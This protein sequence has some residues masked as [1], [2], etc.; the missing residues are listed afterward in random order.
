MLWSIIAVAIAV[1]FVY[2][3]W[4]C[5]SMALS[6]LTCTGMGRI[7]S[8]GDG[9]SV[10]MSFA[11]TYLAISA[12]LHLIVELLGCGTDGEVK[13]EAAVV[14]VPLLEVVLFFVHGIMW[15]NVVFRDLLNLI[16]RLF[17]GL[18]LAAVVSLSCAG[19]LVCSMVVHVH[20]VHLRCYGQSLQ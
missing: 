11:V 10:T 9:F 16:W 13:T 15:L 19:H 7:V 14:P 17:R 1:D 20:G 18:F 6:S 3:S 2:F 8:A 4:E 12:V 5:F